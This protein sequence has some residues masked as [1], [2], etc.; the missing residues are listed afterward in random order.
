VLAQASIDFETCSPVDLTKSGSSRYAR[1]PDTDVICL[2]FAID[3][4]APEVW[5]ATG[6]AP[7]PAALDAHIRAG[8]RV[9]AWN[10]GFERFIWRHIMVPRYGWPAIP[11]GQWSCT[12]SRAMYWG[13]PAGL[14]AAASAL[15]IAA[16]KDKLGHKLMLS[17]CRPKDF[18]DNGKPTYIHQTDPDKRHA[19]IRYCAQDVV[20]EQAIGRAVPQLPDK[21]RTVWLLDQKMNERGIAVDIKLV[22]QMRAIATRAKASLDDRLYVASGQ[23]LDHVTRTQAMHTWLHWQFCPIKDLTRESVAAWRLTEAP[24]PVKD[25]LD[26]RYEAAR[27]STAKLDAMLAATDTDGRLRNTLRYYGASRTGRWSGAGGTRAQLHNLPRPV[28]KNVDAAIAMIEA[29]HDEHALDLLFADSPLG[30]LASCLRGCFRAGPGHALVCVDLA[31]IEARVIAWLAGQ[32]DVLDVFQ[33][34][35]DVYTYTAASIGSTDRQLGKVIRLALGFGMG[36]TRFAATALAYG[37]LLTLEQAST[38]VDAWRAVS[39][40]TLLLWRRLETAMRDCLRNPPGRRY[41]ATRNIFF[42]RGPRGGVAMWLPSGRALVYRNV[43]LEIDP[44][45]D[46]DAITYD[47][48]N[49]RTRQWGP[50]RTYGGKLAENCFAF[51]TLILTARGWVPIETI[52]ATDLLWDGTDW[53]THAG[54]ICRGV[55]GTI[56]VDGVWMTPDHLIMTTKGWCDAAT[57]DGFDRAPVGLPDGAAARWQRKVGRSPLVSPLRMWQRETYQNRRHLPGRYEVLRLSNQGVDQPRAAQA[58]HGGPSTVPRMALNETTLQPSDRPFSAQLWRPG[59]HGLS[60]M[61]RLHR[62][63]AGHGAD[64][65]VEADTGSGGQRAGLQPGELSLDDQYGAEPKQ[66]GQPADQHP[67]GSHDGGRSERTQW[68]QGPDA[69]L[70]PERRRA[71]VYDVLDTGQNHRFVI[72][73]EYGPLIV[74]NCTQAIARDVMVD[75]MLALD[76]AGHDLLLTVHD[77]IISAAPHSQAQAVLDTMLAVTRQAPQWAPGLPVWSEGFIAE[78]YRK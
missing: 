65:S 26:I 37:V 60:G 44:K 11:D 29:G 38:I 7:I 49:Q 76:G 67:L 52:R 27:T 31:Q 22:A 70:P 73:G 48:V 8:H 58:R 33:Q 17:M 45:T 24:G 2:A 64:V 40:D 57:C 34:R 51:G 4:G 3:G 68:H 61:V 66:T 35:G 71:C 15:G 13:L 75:S 46:W 36:A 19:L 30:V 43:R 21:E 1:D 72:A 55:Q 74:H 10:V 16:Q 28:I 69:A 18:G 41:Q 78:R 50:I 5:D 23:M 47:G 32:Q 42:E 77:E 39:G 20:V 53:V 62:V 12:M 14:D 56:C 9:C 63:L 54:L 6:K 59:D 25:V